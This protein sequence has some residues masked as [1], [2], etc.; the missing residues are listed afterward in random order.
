MSFFDSFKREVSSISSNYT[1]VSSKHI[2]I[3]TI[4][5]TITLQFSLSLPFIIFV[6]LDV[7][8]FENMFFSYFLSSCHARL[9]F[10]NAIPA[11]ESI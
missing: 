3:S 11:R 7:Y 2:T 4:T 10:Y 5:T 9:C 1:T 8:Y 6:L